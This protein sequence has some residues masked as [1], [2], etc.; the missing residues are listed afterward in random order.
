MCT[1][2]TFSNVLKFCILHTECI[3]VFVIVLTIKSG[4]ISLNSINRLVFVAET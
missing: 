3:R 1:R 4:F 2:T